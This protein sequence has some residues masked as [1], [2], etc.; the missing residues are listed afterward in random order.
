MRYQQVAST[1]E[2]TRVMSSA[3]AADV[4]SGE[5]VEVDAGWMVAAFRD[6]VALEWSGELGDYLVLDA[7]RYRVVPPAADF[8]SE[9][10]PP[11]ADWST[12]AEALAAAAQGVTDAVA[13]VPAAASAGAIRAALLKLLPNL[14]ALAR[15]LA[16]VLTLYR[17]E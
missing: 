14:G 11:P 5:V 17:K 10:V 13:E 12:E 2:A 1:I 3:Q 8:E 7:D 15:G 9:W 6:D 16:A 4:L